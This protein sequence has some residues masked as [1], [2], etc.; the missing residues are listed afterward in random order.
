[1]NVNESIFIGNVVEKYNYVL[2]GYLFVNK[3]QQIEEIVFG[4]FVS[5]FA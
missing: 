3:S 5:Q 2:F 4:E 1:M